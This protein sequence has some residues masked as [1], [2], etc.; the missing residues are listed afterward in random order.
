MGALYLYNPEVTW[1]KTVANA[2]SHNFS[3]MPARDNDH[4]SFAVAPINWFLTF[5]HVITDE[6]IEC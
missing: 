1:V 6:I 4:A 5:R 2:S 3:M